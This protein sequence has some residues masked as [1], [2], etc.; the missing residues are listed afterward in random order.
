MACKFKY[1]GLEFSS[2]DALVKYIKNSFGS[3]VKSTKQL[4][5]KVSDMD[6]FIF[7]DSFSSIKD[8]RTKAY[9]E[10][11]VNGA[12][13]NGGKIKILQKEYDL[14]YKGKNRDH[15][16]A[17]LQKK[18]VVQEMNKVYGSVDSKI[19][20]WINENG[21]SL[22]PDVLKEVFGETQG[23]S[24]YSSDTL[25][26]LKK[27]FNIKKGTSVYRLSDFK[28]SP[29]FKVIGEIDLSDIDTE[30]YNP[31]VLVNSY[32][33]E[34]GV[35]DISIMD[36]EPYMHF[37]GKGLSGSLI[38]ANF[39]SDKKA[40]DAGV[41]MH[42]NIADIRSIQSSLLVAKMKAVGGDNLF[43]R[44]NNIIQFNGNNEISIAGVNN[45]ESIN[46]IR[47]LRNIPEL[48]GQMSNDMIGLIFNDEIIDEKNMHKDYVSMLMNT[49]QQQIQDLR[50]GDGFHSLGID[51]LEK[52]VKLE[53]AFLADKNRSKQLI[54]A[55]RKQ[56]NWIKKQRK[57]YTTEDQVQDEEYR[58]ISQIMMSI[59]SIYDRTK[60]S[61]DQPGFGAY[62]ST[63]GHM[64]NWVFQNY[65]SLEKRL[66]ME[67]ADLVRQEQSKLLKFLNP[68][69]DAYENN[70]G[71]IIQ[72]YVI[73]NAEKKFDPIFKKKKMKV[74][75][76]DG[77]VTEEEVF[78]GEVHFDKTDPETAK[79]LARGELTE[80]QLALGKY[81][82]ETS[83]KY[84]RE[85][86]F[87]HEYKARF[88]HKS[89]NEKVN[90]TS[91]EGKTVKEYINDTIDE[92]ISKNWKKGMLP[93][94]SKSSSENFANFK[95]LKGLQSYFK[96]DTDPAKIMDQVSKISEVDGENKSSM[97]SFV[98]A[99]I[100]DHMGN[101]EYGSTS[102]ME[103]LGMT[104]GKD[105]V[106]VNRKDN[107]ESLT[108]N[109]F[110]IMSYM[111]TEAKTKPI[112]ENEI[113]PFMED[114]LVYAKALEVFEGE[115]QKMTAEFIR[116]RVDKTIYG[117]SQYIAKGKNDKFGQNAEGVVRLG[118]RA[119]TFSGVALSVPVAVTSF[120]ANFF[121]SVNIAIANKFGNPYDMFN[122]N[123][124]NKAFY[125]TMK[126]NKKV[127]ALG[128]YYQVYEGE[129]QELLNNIKWD[130]SQKQIF[131]S[132]R[133]HFMN[134]WTDRF[135]REVV[136]VAQ[137]MHD[138]TY[139]AHSIE[140]GEVKYDAKKD[141][142]Y[143]DQE[144]GEQTEVQKE[145]MNWIRDD[146]VND[147]A[148]S[149]DPEGLP[150]K[151]YSREDQE[152]FIFI[153]NEFVVGAFDQYRGTVG[154]NHLLYN[155]VF[156]FKKFAVPKI[157]RRI[158][159]TRPV[160][161]AALRRIEEG[162][163]QELHRIWDPIIREG[164]WRTTSDLLLGTVPMV[165]D[166]LAKI[167]FVKKRR[168]MEDWKNMS[169]LEKHN[170]ASTALD[171]SFFI[172]GAILYSG[173]KGLSDDDD[174]DKDS[175]IAFLGPR[176]IRSLRDGLWTAIVA[177]QVNE[178]FL[179]PFPIVDYTKRLLNIFTFSASSGDLERM[180]PGMA[181]IDALKDMNQKEK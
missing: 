119:L 178:M 94:L 114:A 20:K 161:E 85:I 34:T 92:I 91:M 144:T 170:L 27:I 63:Q 31:L 73:N 116:Q 159:S 39:T 143:F 137:M 90:P 52:L 164:T 51:K 130:P 181:N 129:I 57:L 131:D 157:Q 2:K 175:P 15:I 99:Q 146:L 155:V 22:H 69:V 136:M 113:L 7:S 78:T 25:V 128:D 75:D 55:L 141:A 142:R 152:K 126:N 165:G 8:Y 5:N 14:E 71:S 35:L 110:T 44:K 59:E 140:D 115:E 98:V 167:G 93:V 160:R 156:Q 147:R 62:F 109:L 79:L 162:D 171:L 6:R 53:R 117:K 153:G 64:K 168:T 104:I 33:G 108:K 169:E 50:D 13:L 38:T 138:G 96:Q 127:R 47:A 65:S 49:H 166:W 61:I 80:E 68:V 122:L 125:E 172:M 43:V 177:A 174:Y 102:R 103:M 24:T 45:Y 154:D 180:V 42:A 100:K 77:N 112:I 134:R 9:E 41:T 67:G 97:G 149:Q 18:G 83:L 139:K 101:K 133:M 37:S 40:K 135:F 163:D 29:A 176:L 58:L 86:L 60:G 19:L 95:V 23:K 106:E 158:G 107:N 84:I 74:T 3:E 54:D 48:L 132:T 21:A 121:E 17:L 105:G 36:I 89:L 88:S 148:V 10:M 81:V 4:M 32:D 1:D 87:Q 118:M 11:L 151:A 70:L 30:I 82:A 46:N 56:Q 66:M 145:L 179:E 28:A 150:V 76:E 111:A 124:F 123:E 120:T 72:S 12:I 26:Q 173:L 16:K